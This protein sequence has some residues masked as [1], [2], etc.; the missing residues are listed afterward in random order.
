[1][2][3]AFYLLNFLSIRII[4]FTSC[5]SHIIKTSILAKFFLFSSTSPTI[6]SCNSSPSHISPSLILLLIF[7][8]L[9]Q[10]IYLQS[11]SVYNTQ[12][13]QYYTNYDNIGH[14]PQWFIKLLHYQSSS[15]FQN[16]KYPFYKHSSWWLNRILIFFFPNNIALPPLNGYYM[17]GLTKYVMTLINLY[18]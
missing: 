2:E 4:F 3:N 17:Q 12:I 16:S 1:M 11:F 6:S 14:V 18:G 8:L 7:F 10:S 15:I 5:T 9:Q 13:I